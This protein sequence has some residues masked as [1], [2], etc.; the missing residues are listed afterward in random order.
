MCGIYGLINFNDKPIEKELLF[1]MGDKMIHR[2]PDGEGYITFD[3]I[4]IGMRRLAIIDP[5]GGQQPISNEDETIYIV[6][7]GEIYNHTELRNELLQ[8]GHRFKTKS[9]VECVIHLYEELGTACINRLNGMFAFALFDKKQNRLWLARDRLG[10]KPLF[11]L[12]SDKQFIF[13]SDLNAIKTI[14]NVTVKEEA[15]IKY[16]GFS[17]VPEPETI[18][19]DVYKLGCGEQI[20]IEN[21]NFKH[22][23]YWTPHVSSTFVGS[24]QEATSK[25]EAI[26]FESS[27]LQ[28]RSDVPIGVFLSGGIDS[29]A[30]AAFVAKLNTQN[31]IKTFTVNFLGKRGQDSKYAKII[32]DTIEAK[33][34]VIELDSSNLALALDELLPLM[35]EPLSDSAIVPTYIISK[36]AKKKGIKVLLSGAGGDEVFGGYKRHFPMRFG[37]AAWIAQHKLIR[38]LFKIITK[39]SHPHLSRR[40]ASPARNFAIS[41][42]GANLELLSEAFNNNEHFHKL[43]LNFEKIFY[44]AS[45]PKIIDRMRLD[46][47]TYLPNN[48]MSLTDKATMAASVEGRVPLLDHRLVEF[49]FSLPSDFNPLW[50]KDKGLFKNL[51]IN[52]LPK[53]ILNRKKEG[54]SA[55]MNNWV[56]SDPKII[57]EELLGNTTPILKNLLNFKI[58]ENWLKNPKKRHVAG[59]TIFSI[60]IL[61]KWLSLKTNL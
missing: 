12:K 18:Y 7:N 48:I 47:Q 35:D 30:I 49:A 38:N 43:L 27:K 56:E 40:L 25:L 36:Y 4:G 50:G 13:S 46:L 31:A 6:L 60:Y 61:N 19:H 55:P 17:Y 45:S 1:A 20:T 26:L 3:K 28:I 5:S 54:F 11:Y 10:I 58:I 59:D 29:S 34:N 42:S 24:I 37:S 39:Y 15:L 2:G 9:D 32:A 22:S 33:H 23:S 8:R 41:I 16:L 51:L 53:E 52:H 44:D 57:S 21:S 14:K